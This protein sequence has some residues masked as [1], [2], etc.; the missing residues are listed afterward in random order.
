M[1]V[2]RTSLEAYYN[3]I[4]DKKE[5]SQDKKILQ[6]VKEIQP[7]TCK[8]LELKTGLPINV[9]SRSVFNLKNKSKEIE[10]Y[11]EAKCKVTGRKAQHYIVKGTEII[12][13]KD[14]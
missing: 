8:Q 14:L 6:A 10:M 3:E 11:F 12:E 5:V 4:K 2:A 9:V 1:T 7:C 13:R